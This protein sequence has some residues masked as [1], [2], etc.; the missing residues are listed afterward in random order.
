MIISEGKKNT[1]L[2]H[3]QRSNLQ[4]KN[5]D[6]SILWA[7]MFAV[8]YTL[9]NINKKDSNQLSFQKRVKQ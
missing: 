5:A 6:K 7:T 1:D 3:Q 9:C 8:I 2:I 4:N